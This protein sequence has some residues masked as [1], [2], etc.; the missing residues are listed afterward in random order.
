MSSKLTRRD[1][2]R[3]TTITAVGIAAASCAQPTAAPAQPTAAPAQPTAAPAKP[4]DTP[5]PVAKFKEAP[6][7]A[8]LVKAGKLPPVDE[9]L[10]EDPHVVTPT[11]RIGKYGG[12]WRCG[13]LGPADGALFTRNVEYENLVRWTT[14]W[15]DIIPDICTKW[16]VQDEGKT[17]VFYLRKGMKWSDGEPYT[18]DDYTFRYEEMTNKELSPTFSSTWSTKGGPV[19]VSKIDDYTV[20]FAF[21]DPYGLFLQRMATPS[22]TNWCGPAHYRKQFFPGGDEAAIKKMITDAGVGNWFEAYGNQVNNRLNPDVPVIYG[23]KYTSKLGDSNQ[24]VAERNPYYW[25][26]DPEGNQ[27][28]YIDRQVYTVAGDAQSIVMA[29]LAG[30]ISLQGRHIASI[31]NKPLF[32]QNA[33]TADIRLIPNQGSSMN[34]LTL[35]LNLT[36][37]DPVMREIFQNKDFRIAL[38]HAINRQELVD[39]VALGLGEPWQCA[40]LPESPLYNE[41]LAKQYTEFDPAKANEMLDKILPKKDAEGMRLRPDGQ[42]LGIVAEVASNQQER[43]DMLE[44]I[45]KY[46]ADV[47]IRMAVKAEDRALL[48]ERKDANECDM[49][50]WGGDGGMDVILEPRWYFPYSHESNYAQAWVTWYETRG[51]EGEEPVAAAKKQ[52]EL[53]DTLL[54]TPDVEKQNDLMREILQIAQEEFWCMGCY[55][56]EPGYYVC[57]NKFR[58]VPEETLG[59]WLYPDPGPWNPCQFFW[60]V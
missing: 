5:A 27:L 56:G 24:F 21:A 8:E 29:A 49:A 32:V 7:L 30:E 10:P 34:S 28:P 57:K 20:K 26:V 39:V 35:P 52:M 45:K 23:W 25:K 46:W 59:S 1:F 58:N 38:S 14:D 31:T 6:A 19:V 55:K 48:Y 41:T 9:R 53:Y 18:A 16:E 4:T 54:I 40:P 47:G 33:Q 42:P 12:D 13:T 3:W 37:K 2:L 17:F 51:V 50:V 43:I 15:T 60:D 44:M 11:E 22:G 36:H